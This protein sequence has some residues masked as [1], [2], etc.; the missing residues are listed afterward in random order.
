MP[1]TAKDF[2]ST[3]EEWAEQGKPVPTEAMWQACGTSLHT[4][5]AQSRA[6]RKRFRPLRTR[7]IVV[8]DLVANHGKMLPTGGPAHLTVWFRANASPQSAFTADAE[9][10][11]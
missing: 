7:K 2:R 1:P 5:L 10:T 3:F 11:P 9:A 6:T 8:G 4:D